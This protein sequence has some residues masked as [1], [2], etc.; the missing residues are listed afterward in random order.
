[1]SDCL[2]CRII[3]RELPSQVVFENDQIMII[4]DIEPVAPVHLLAIPKKHIDN[5]CDPRILESTTLNAIYS[6]VQEVV[7]NLKIKE[8]GFRLVSNVGRDAGETIP[9]FH[10]HI[11]AGRKLDTS[12]G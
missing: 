4:K 2:F 9:H 7:E 8:S 12:M 11:I 3:A 1:M 10:M 6:G 5:A